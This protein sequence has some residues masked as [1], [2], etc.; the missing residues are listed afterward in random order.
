[1]AAAAVLAVVLVAGA[2]AL[3]ARRDT[4]SG[5]ERAQQLTKDDDRFGSARE[6]AETLLEVSDL[7]ALEAE[8]CEAERDEHPRDCRPYFAGAGYARIASVRIVTCTRPEVFDVRVAV[9][10]YLAALGESPS[11]AE[12]PAPPRCA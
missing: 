2:A 8:R 12:L 7:L 9:D 11:D 6:G 10:A 3:L 1:M 5:V 4:P